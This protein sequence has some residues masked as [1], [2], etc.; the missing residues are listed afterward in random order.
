M[1]DHPSLTIRTFRESAYCRYLWVNVWIARLYATS[2][3]PT[4]QEKCLFLYE[5][6]WG[7]IMVK[8]ICMLFSCTIC[9]RDDSSNI[10]TAG[11]GA[12]VVDCCSVS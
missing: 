7:H 1:F 5:H 11:T 4:S 6:K 9:A 10:I 3:V 2:G 8:K 12:M